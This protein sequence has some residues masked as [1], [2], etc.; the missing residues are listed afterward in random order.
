MYVLGAAHVM[1]WH[2]GLELYSAILVGNLNA[3]ERLVLDV[4]DVCS[5]AVSPAAYS[6]VDALL[7]LSTSFLQ[8]SCFLLTVPLACHKSTAASGIGSQVVISKT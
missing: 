8:H 5:N 3:T 1:T 2:D 4:P 6:T 7:R